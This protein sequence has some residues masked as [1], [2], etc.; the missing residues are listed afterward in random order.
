MDDGDLQTLHEGS[1]VGDLVVGPEIGRGAFSRVFRAYDEV[2]GRNVALKVLTGVGKDEDSRRRAQRELRVLGVLKSAHVVTLYRVHPDHA[3]TWM[4]ELELVEGGNLADRVRAE[5][6]FS[7][8]ETRRILTGVLTGLDAAHG[9]LVVHRDVKPENVLLGEDGVAKLTDFGF[10]RELSER[11]LADSSRGT[12]VGTPYYV[13]PEILFGQEARPQSDIWSVGVLLHWMIAGSL[14]F[15]GQSLPALFNAIA[16]ML[17]A[18]LPE[19]TPADLAS[20]VGGCLKKDPATRF[21]SCGAIL[22][23]LDGA[24]SH[25]TAEPAPRPVPAPDES[26][27]EVIGREAERERLHARWSEARSGH[28]KALLLSG[29]EGIGKSLLLEDVVA[30]ARRGRAFHLAARVSPV[31]GLQHA[32]VEA[33][34]EATDPSASAYSETRV[35][36]DEATFGAAAEPLSRFLGGTTEGGAQQTTWAID[37][38]LRA[39]T[40]SRPAIFT[41]EDLQCCDADGVRLLRGLLPRLEKL[42]VLVVLALRTHDLDASESGSTDPAGLARLAA[43]EEVEHVPVGPLSKRGAMDLASHV[44]GAERL[45]P[46]LRRT[47]WSRTEGVPYLLV[48]Y[49]RHLRDEGVVRLEDAT[50]RLAMP[51]ATSGLPLRLQ[52]L[53]SARLAGLPQTDHDLLEAAAVAGLDFRGEDVADVLEQPLLRVLR[54]L[55]RLCRDRELLRPERDAYRF[56]HALLRDAIYD[57]VAPA[58]RTAYHAQYA[59]RLEGR[60]DLSDVDHERLGRH[61]VAAGE[62]VRAAAHLEKAA[63]AAT[64]RQ[65]H[66]RAIELAKLAGLLDADLGPERVHA[67]SAF[68][69]RIAGALED[70]DRMDEARALL[71]RVGAAALALGDDTLFATHAIWAQDLEA[72]QVGPSAVDTACLKEALPRTNDWRA[73]ARAHYLMAE[74]WK[75]EGRL[76]DATEALEAALRIHTENGSSRIR[77]TVVHELGALAAERLDHVE[78]RSRYEE[79][80][81]LCEAAFQPINAAVS[82][83]MAGV[84]ALAQGDALAAAE[85]H[86]RSIGEMEEAGAHVLAACVRSFRSR[87]LLSLGRHEDAREESDLALATLDRATASYATAGPYLWGLHLAASAGEAAKTARCRTAFEMRAARASDPSER[88]LAQ[89]ALSLYETVSGHADDAAALLEAAVPAVL[90]RPPTPLRATRFAL[91]LLEARVFGCDCLDLTGVSDLLRTLEEGGEVARE[92]ADAIVAARSVLG[93]SPTPELLE[94][95]ARPF[96]AG[97]LGERQPEHR[98]IARR[99]VA[100]PD[101]GSAT[102]AHLPPWIAHLEAGRTSL[103]AGGP[104]PSRSP[105]H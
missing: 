103:T 34:R 79:A 58:L 23:I 12:I 38:L 62:P 98:A 77:P 75:W 26:R 41:L 56:D 99:L 24:R 36:I 44:L 51:L 57:R 2:I 104:R 69:F 72:Y 64:G 100:R 66:L 16:A 52:E 87:A 17:P 91:L 71:G 81:R 55:Q 40:R 83:A 74:H 63:L 68:L 1:R 86:A 94:R 88:T 20:V 50:L 8:E 78:A 48:E 32:L 21:G 18:P 45:P 31:G 35:S 22:E 47:L 61:W 90:Q 13:A 53:V 30:E 93:S 76:R 95:V 85:V 70:V 14:P 25:R 39:V 29:P 37:T 84:T 80:A 11:S 10:G 33:V 89:A 97:R 3:G 43:S 4:L 9:H 73:Q 19:G 7:A 67:S 96:A 65:E 28:G 82:R 92:I 49:V 102:E 101:D 59:T 15:Q 27:V 46:E 6:P 42:P 54:S 60:A 105:A 5:G